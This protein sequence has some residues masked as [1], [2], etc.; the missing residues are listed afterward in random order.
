[1]ANNTTFFGNTDFG[2]RRENNEDA[3]VIENIW[4]DDH[5]LAVAIDGVGGY[6]GGEV[7]AAIAQ[8][9]IP[10][11]LRNYPN[12][13]RCELLKQAVIYA[14]NSIFEKRQ[15]NPELSSM[16]CVLTA[17]L[18]EVKNRRINMA[19]VGDTRLYELANGTY[20]KLSR[21]HSLVG[22]REEIGDLTEEEA[23][24][25]PQRNIISR[26]VGSKILQSNSDDYIYTDTFPLQA[27]SSLLLCSDG[28]CDMVTSAQMRAVLE[29]DIPTQ[30]KVNALIQAANDA[31][32]KDNITVVIVETHFEE[33]QRNNVHNDNV[34][35]E[36]KIDNSN[37]Y[38]TVTR[39]SAPTTAEP[40]IESSSS[41][42]S[43]GS[44]I[45]LDDEPATAVSPA[46]LPPLPNKQTSAPAQPQRQSTTNAPKAPTHQGRTKQTPNATRPRPQA[47]S[48]NTPHKNPI[49]DQPHVEVT[50]V[51]HSNQPN[52]M[53]SYSENEDKTKLSTP[54]LS[55]I[56]VFAAVVVFFAGYFTKGY[57]SPEFGNNTYYEQTE[58]I[59]ATTPETIN[60]IQV[61]S[62]ESDSTKTQNDSVVYI[63]VNNKDLY[64]RVIKNDSTINTQDILNLINNNKLIPKIKNMPKGNQATASADGA[65]ADHALSEEEINKCPNE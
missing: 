7:A 21:D 24:R 55:S 8:A 27:R 38:V 4:D 9:C 40:N 5:I 29:Q 41:N 49:N 18:I 65:S 56:I 44:A 60:N 33:E 28:L 3:F 39:V 61:I 50:R 51:S 57:I 16:S 35:T 20:R 37:P 32:G 34:V 31:G 64:N 48:A 62:L 11:Y 19:H 43:T 30:D 1:M 25:H 47:H 54:I 46:K 52:Y 42:N 6:E 26:D 2:R 13:E 12:G 17:A 14:N 58:Y 10:E 15:Q 22:Y 36:Q 63:M 53:P 59:D 23:M 45:S